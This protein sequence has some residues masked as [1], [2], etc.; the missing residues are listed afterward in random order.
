M[1]PPLS[2]KLETIAQEGTDEFTSNQPTEPGIVDGHI[3]DVDHD[4]PLRKDLHP[5]DWTARMPATIIRFYYDA[6]C[7]ALQFSSSTS[8]NVRKL[9]SFIGSPLLRCQVGKSRTPANR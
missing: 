4:P 6:K 8:Q 2:A 1:T 7:V 9:S 5:K 3:S